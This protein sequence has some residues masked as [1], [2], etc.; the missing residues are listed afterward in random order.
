MFS[1]SKDNDQIS[2]S[3]LKPNNYNINPPA[4]IQGK[5]LQENSNT[6]F[7]F[8]T[9]D[10]CQVVTPSISNCYKALIDMYKNTPSFEVN[11]SEEV[12]NTRYYVVLKIGPTEYSYE[13]LKI[14]EDTLDWYMSPNN[15]P[16]TLTKQ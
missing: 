3:G 8:R 1:C 10:V 7:E 12:S 15:P 16:V 13:F 6:G 14:S 4:W 5:W 11:V 2:E 9:N